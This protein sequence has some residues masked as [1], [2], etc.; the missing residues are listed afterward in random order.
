MAFRGHPCPYRNFFPA[1][2]TLARKTGLVSS[3]LMPWNGFITA[4][5]H[6]SYTSL[7]N[8]RMASS[9][10]GLVGLIGT[11]AEPPLPADEGADPPEVRPRSV[12]GGAVLAY[13]AMG[14]KTRGFWRGSG[15]E[16][17]VLGACGRCS[18]MNLVDVG[19]RKQDR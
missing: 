11:D 7:K 9:V 12:E 18:R 14:V 3:W 10:C 19:V 17:G 4:F 8:K 2:S 6:A 5:T 16:G 15:T 13:G 1:A